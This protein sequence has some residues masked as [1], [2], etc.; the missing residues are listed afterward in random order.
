MTFAA[1]RRPWFATLSTAMA[2]LLGVAVVMAVC[3]AAA[4]EAP[5]WSVSAPPL[6]LRG[7]PF[8]VTV[9]AA[10][11]VSLRLV[12]TGSP[13]AEPAWRTTRLGVEP[14]GPGRDR[15][16]E[17]PGATRTTRT[18][19]PLRPL[20]AGPGE[21]EVAGITVLRAGVPLAFTDGVHTVEVAPRVV[22]GWLSILPPLLAIVLALVWRQVLVALL[23]GVWLGATILTGFNP[24]TAFLRVGDQF[25]VMALADASHASIVLFSTTLGGMV[26]ILA[27]AGATE[28]VVRALAGRV[29]GRRGGQVTTAAMGTAIF[30]DDYANTL[31]VGSTMRPLTDSLRISREKLAYLVDSTAAPIATLAV[32]S[33]WVGFEVGLIQ[34]AMADLGREDGSAYTFFL[35]SLPYGY[36][37]WLTLVMVYVVAGTGRDWGPMLA[38]ERR[39]SETGLLLRPGARPASESLGEPEPAVD[40]SADG[41]AAGTQAAGRPR[42][43]GPAHPALALVPIGLVILTTAGGLVYSGLVGARAAGVPDAGLR[44]LLNHA[45]SFA[46]LMWAALAGALV[47]GVLAVAARRLTLRGA[48]DGWLDGARAML[49]AVT[50]LLLAWALSAVC[51]ELHT[52]DYLVDVTRGLLSARLLP[53]VVFLLAAAVSFATGTSWGTMAILMPL[54]YPLGALLPGSEG[55]AEATAVRI[56]LASVSA[57]LAGAVFG[58]HCSPISDTTIMSSLASGSDHVDHVRTQLPYAATVAAVAVV[59]GYVPVGYGVSPLISLPLGVVFVIAIALLAGRRPAR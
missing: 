1:R 3:G 12:D 51:S 34:E 43:R 39:A 32:I 42:P 2:A 8:T 56:H 46:V 57:V 49:I 30:F 14:D 37:P 21:T 31:L 22:P 53:A 55:I 23:L 50:I 29:G 25:L 13:A 18:G 35:R 58:D 19:E 28:G 20:T 45:D 52:A 24:L 11:T 54:V 47:A 4:A 6:V 48:V 36:Y 10:D 59:T 38:A 15:P 9:T 7:V 16:G 27:R 40:R 41:G 26:G 17:S 44:E 33:T 5:A